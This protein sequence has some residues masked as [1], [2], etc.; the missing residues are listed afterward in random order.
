MLF[1]SLSR[2]ISPAVAV[3]VSLPPSVVTIDAPLMTRSDSEML[4]ASIVTSPPAVVLPATITAPL[5]ATLAVSALEKLPI[6]SM[7][8][9]VKPVPSEK[10]TE[11]VPPETW[12]KTRLPPATSVVIAS[13]TVLP[14][15]SVLP[16][17]LKVASPKEIPLPASSIAAA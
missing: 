17:V 10:S 9:V 4:P 7:P 5:G 3:A 13:I 1:A 11:T 14:A 2:T 8:S 16:S 6:K 12:S 15:S